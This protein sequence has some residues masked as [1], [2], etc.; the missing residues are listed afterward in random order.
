MFPIYN[1]LKIPEN[2]MSPGVFR[3][4]KIRAIA[5][6]GLTNKRFDY[7]MGLGSF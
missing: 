3:G 6:Y 1:L 2:R 7:L 5:R 4:Y